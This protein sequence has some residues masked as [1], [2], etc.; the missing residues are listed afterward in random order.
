MDLSSLT[1]I[2]PID[3]R[4]GNKTVALR[5]IFSEYGLLRFRILT[6]IR[7]FQALAAAPEIPELPPLSGPANAH[8]ESIVDEFDE[9]AAGRIK[10]FERTTNHDVKAVEYY[11]KERLAE[12]PDL[13]PHVEFVHFACTSEDINNVAHALMLLAGRDEVLLPVMDE[14]IST[15]TELA[16]RFADVP[17][18]SRTHGQVASPT[19]MGKELANFAWRLQERRRTLAAVPLPAKLNGAVGNYNAHIVTCP[20]VDWQ[21]LSR[22]VLEGLGLQWNPYTT[23]I[24]PH[25][26]IAEYC[27]A[28]MRCNQ[29]LLD[30]D[31]DMWGYISLGYFRQRKVATETGSSVMPHKVN[32]IDFENSEGN[33]GLAN[34]VLAHLADKLPVSR[35]QRDLSDSTVLRNLGVGVAHTLIALEASLRGLGKVELDGARLAEDLA[36]SWEVLA[37]PL[38]TL[39]RREGV[40]SPYEK[41]KELTRGERL[42]AESMQRLIAQLP[43]SDTARA[44][45]QTMTP[46]DYTGLAAELARALDKQR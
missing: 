16:H 12:H 11:L 28:L 45:L 46:A 13:R 18:L 6:E 24:E 25:D 10:A 7:W 36:A 37:E 8:L 34:A 14:L 9:A 43:L 31:R 1:A 42:D 41:L 35:W 4:Y 21:A 3:G 26:G 20:E 32:P 44:R 29:V 33:L 5:P 27:H 22:Q 17:M 38:Q 23:Q 39:M 2:S 30:L 15:V 40:E 19:T